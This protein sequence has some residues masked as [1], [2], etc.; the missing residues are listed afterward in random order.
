MS[1]DELR[2]RIS[3]LHRGLAAA[4]RARSVSG[5]APLRGSGLEQRLP[6]VEVRDTPHGKLVVCT[7][8]LSDIHADAQR[9]NRAYLRA[10]GRAARLAEREALP[11]FLDPM[12]G[13][14]PERTALI[15]TETA[16]LHGRPLFMIGMARLLRD[17]LILTQYFAR[18]YPEE[19]GLLH[20]FASVLPDLDL[21]ISFNGKAFDWPF[22]RDRMVY[23]RLRCDHS[24]AHLDLLHAARRRWRARL[25]NCK[26]QTLERY[27][28]GRWRSGDIPGD[29]IPQHYHDFVREQDARLIAPVFHHNRLDLITMVELLAAL[30]NGETP[31]R[32]T[33]PDGVGA[34]PGNAGSPHS[35]RAKGARDV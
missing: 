29:Q 34:A 13:A 14:D 11:P 16:G 6:G 9:L 4:P 33:L 25:P 8:A 23:H 1:S 3:L 17:D 18:S 20:E 15:D 5:R 30:V 2:Q 7:A 19:A 27:L 12:V 28:C 35:G 24:F 31:S 22:V 21:L 10:F 26:L 32:S